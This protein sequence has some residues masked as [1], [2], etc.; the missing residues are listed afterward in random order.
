VKWAEE[1]KLYETKYFKAS[2]E[3]THASLTEAEVE[4][5]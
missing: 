5:I 4:L 3:P 2:D 1:T